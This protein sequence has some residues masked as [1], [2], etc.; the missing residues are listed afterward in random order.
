MYEE[1]TTKSRSQTKKEPILLHCKTWE[2]WDGLQ[3]T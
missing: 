3:I 2:D 1:E